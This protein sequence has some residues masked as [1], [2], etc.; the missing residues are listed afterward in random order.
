AKCKATGIQCLSNTKQLA[1][2]WHLYSGDFNDRLANNYGVNETI[3]AIG[4]GIN[5][6]LDNW[7]NNV[8]TWG[9]STAI[10]DVSN[11]NV[12]WIANGTLGQYTASTLGVYRCPADNYLAP[13]SYHCRACDFSF[14]DAHSEIR[15][16]KS[17]SSVYS[18][19]QYF[20]PST[21]AFD[22]AGKADFAWYLERTGYIL[23]T[24]GAPQFGY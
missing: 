15:K 7:V 3:E 1:F 12:A 6:K 18:T 9:A 24:S 19:V 11:T 5:G 4:N 10:A 21:K 17:G 8:M 14:A 2:A 22:V 16:W 13:A 20:Y 23:A